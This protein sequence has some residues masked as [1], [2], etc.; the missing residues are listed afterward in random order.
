MTMVRS[1]HGA[2]IAPLLGALAL[3]ALTTPAQ[4]QVRPGSVE[5]GVLG[6]FVE[7]DEL[8]DNAGIFGVRAAYNLSRV[9]GFE[10]R[11]TG[12]P[13]TKSAPIFSPS[14]AVQETIREDVFIQ[15]LGFNA[16]LN[17]NSGIINPYL[18]GGAGMVFLDGTHFAVNM[19]IGTRI[20]I[21]DF[22]FAKVD[23]RGWFSSEAPG[24]DEYA[25]FHATAGFGVQLGGDFDMDGDGVPNTED[26]CPTTAED[27]DDFEDSDGCPEDDND[28]DGVKDADD[29]CPMKAEDKDDDRDDDGCPD[30]DDDNDGIDNDTDKCKDV[31][32]D[33]DGFEDDDGCPEKDNDKDGI[34]D[35][36][37]L[38]P[39]EAETKNNWAD[40]DGCPELDTDKDGVWNIV[41]KCVDAAETLNG[42][43]D[44][45]GCP[46]EV[47]AD[48]TAVLGIQTD[49]KF[50]R[51]SEA[52]FRRS[53]KPLDAL[54][55]V[56]KR[57]PKATIEVQT[58]AF[59]VPDAV[60]LSNKRSAGVWSYLTTTGGVAEGSLRGKG[61]G[62]A[63]LPADAPK[64]AKKDRLEVHLFV[65]TTQPQP[66]APTLD[67]LKALKARGGKAMTKFEE[68]AEKAKKAAEARA[69]KAAPVVPA[70]AP[71]VPAA[72]PAV[73]PAAAP[74]VPDATPKAAT[75]KADTPKAP[76]APNP[77]N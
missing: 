40:E 54:A 21:N 23:V 4:A 74:V 68:R 45:D 52:I 63:A 28:K 30:I 39:L 35:A 58:T 10:V 13:T 20:H 51:K 27:K 57:H 15:Q 71:V 33:K 73:V 41:D 38:C 61:I 46:D 62:D 22:F 59:G 65:P 53:L 18:A 60:A 67:E 44:L 77:P 19:G 8:Y 76:S 75:P 49:I 56:L 32:E 36:A 37:D 50:E 64:G 31:P 48:L 12:S 69:K 42:Y 34:D 29:K 16:L 1:L 24:A 25:H 26:K 55:A 9:I 72:V 2:R 3:A 6:G 66:K 17:L 43:D 5:F 14:G 7:G 11:Y 70:A 47:P